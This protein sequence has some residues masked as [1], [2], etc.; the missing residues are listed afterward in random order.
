VQVT[1]N[2]VDIVGK[3]INGVPALAARTL[4][5]R[6]VFIVADMDNFG[7]KHVNDLI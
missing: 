7:I 2:L 4:S 3:D 5:V 6:I 1:V